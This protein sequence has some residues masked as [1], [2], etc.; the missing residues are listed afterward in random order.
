MKSTSIFCASLL[1][2]FIGGSLAAE[3]KTTNKNLR[4]ISGTVSADGKTTIHEELLDQCIASLPEFSSLSPDITSETPWLKK[5]MGIDSNA[6]YQ[7]V[8]NAKILI[9]YRNRHN[10]LLIISQNGL[11][12]SEPILKEIKTEAPAQ[13]LIVSDLSDSDFFAGNSP[14]VYYFASAE[15]AEKSARKRA[16]IW[17][18]ANQHLIC[19]DQ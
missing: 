9:N 14:R 16:E 8:Y 10:K 12:K 7:K 2:I 6:A 18:K 3:T 1:S 17:L 11:E 15:A 19:K 4:L 5:I 13:K